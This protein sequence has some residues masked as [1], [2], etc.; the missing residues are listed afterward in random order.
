MLAEAGYTARV[1]HH[2]P[3]SAVIDALSHLLDEEPLRD[4]TGTGGFT[5]SHHARVDVLLRLAREAHHHTRVLGPLLGEYDVVVA[6]QGLY[7]KLAYALAVLAETQPDA[8]P[9]MLLTGLR[10]LVA[11]WFLHPDVAVFLDTPWP[12]ARERAIARGHGGGNPGSV[13]RLMFLPQFAA[14]YRLVLAAHQDRVARIRV[15]LRPPDQ[16]LS[17]ITDALARLL[18]APLNGAPSDA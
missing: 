7:S 1:V 11:P 6:D 4:R 14:A 12:L 17:Q 18:G 13:E 10:G 3:R 16:V 15:G 5:A 8:D 2:G 9:T